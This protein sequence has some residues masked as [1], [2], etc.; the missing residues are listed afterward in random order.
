MKKCIRRIEAGETQQAI[1]RE[2]DVPYTKW[3]SL[4]SD[5]DLTCNPQRGRRAAVYTLQKAKEVRRRAKAGEF[6][7]DICNDM[8]MDY[9]NFCRFCHNNDITILNEKEM[10]AN[11]KR[12]DRSNTGRKKG[13]KNSEGKGA[14]I[15][16]ELA[17][18]RDWKK[19]EKTRRLRSLHEH[20]P[21][22]NPRNRLTAILYKK[23]SLIPAEACVGGDAVGA[24]G[25]MLQTVEADGDAGTRG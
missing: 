8:G 13:V 15:K 23:S 11:I 25:D 24:G 16:A 12:R 7:S 18:G 22:R 1:L 6:I 9:R 3:R 5:Y 10:K 2:L 20:A 14:K 21:Q 4:L 17:K 19:V